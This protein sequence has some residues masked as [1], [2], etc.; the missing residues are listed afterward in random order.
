VKQVE[1]VLG[2][3]KNNGFVKQEVQEVGEAFLVKQKKQV[4]LKQKEQMLF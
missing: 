3:Q 4:L 2:K 1:K